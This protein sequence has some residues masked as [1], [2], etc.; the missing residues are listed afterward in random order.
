[1]KR[2][3]G[4]PCPAEFNNSEHHKKQKWREFTRAGELLVKFL[5]LGSS[6]LLTGIGS[7]SINCM[8]NC[9]ARAESMLART[10]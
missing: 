8:A 4:P 9:Q 3:L 1:L 10:R 7:R 6:Q 2:T 5:E